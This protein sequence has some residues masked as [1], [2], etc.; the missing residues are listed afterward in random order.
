MGYLFV[1]SGA[2]PGTMIAATS[3]KDNPSGPLEALS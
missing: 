2:L 1:L 3:V